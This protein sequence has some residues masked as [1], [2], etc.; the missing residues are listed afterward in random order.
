MAEIKPFNSNKPSWLNKIDYNYNIDF[1]FTQ[2]KVTETIEF[3]DKKT[4]ER[5]NKQETKIH[6]FLALNFPTLKD[7][8]FPLLIK[9]EVWGDKN[10]NYELYFL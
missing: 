3:I 7:L 1:F 6:N 2:R 10:F 8:N 4:L 9:I 5:K